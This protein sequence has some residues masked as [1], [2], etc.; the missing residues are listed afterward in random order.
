MRVYPAVIGITW[1]GCA[2]GRDGQRGTELG[3]SDGQAV[4]REWLSQKPTMNEYCCIGKHFL[5]VDH[6]YCI[7]DPFV[8]PASKHEKGPPKRAL[9]G[10]RAGDQKKPSLFGL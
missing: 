10:S 9:A 1:R 4:A 5:A 2:A 3:G 7:A 8:D 6:A